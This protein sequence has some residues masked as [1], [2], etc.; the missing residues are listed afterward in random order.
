MKRAIAVAAACAAVL[1]AGGAMASA[2]ERWEL[3]LGG[4]AVGT[5]TVEQSGAGFTGAGSFTFQGT[6]IETS[7]QGGSRL[8]NPKGTHRPTGSVGTIVVK[9]VELMVI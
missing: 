8:D 6:K 5:E 4:T 1:T 7:Y 9:T 3:L 2:E